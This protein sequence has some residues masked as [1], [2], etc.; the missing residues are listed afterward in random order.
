MLGIW[1][2]LIFIFGFV[3]CSCPELQAI[4]LVVALFAVYVTRGYILKSLSLLALTT[5]IWLTY[6]HFIAQ[7]NQERAFENFRE[8][9]C[10]QFKQQSNKSLQ[11][12][13]Q[14]NPVSAKRA[15]EAETRFHLLCP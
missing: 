2:F 7:Q 11:G 10:L 4:A 15:K 1:L 13:Q 3:M 6:T 8:K 14:A 9:E 12:T 5:S